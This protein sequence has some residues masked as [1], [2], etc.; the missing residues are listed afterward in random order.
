MLG[1]KIRGNL[2]MCLRR[3]MVFRHWNFEG[4]GRKFFE[5]LE[6]HIFENA[7][8]NGWQLQILGQQHTI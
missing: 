8:V 4:A 5:K 7:D 6:T 2:H 3:H 1:M